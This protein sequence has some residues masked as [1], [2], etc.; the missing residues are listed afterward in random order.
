MALPQSG[1]A[2]FVDS[3][4]EALSTLRSGYGG[5]IREDGIGERGEGKLGYYVKLKKNK[6]KKRKE[7]KA[8]ELQVSCNLHFPAKSPGAGA[9]NDQK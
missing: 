8:T 6:E 4:R 9:V 2:D 3:P 1:I 5:G 7:S